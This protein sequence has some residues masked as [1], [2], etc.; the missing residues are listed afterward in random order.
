MSSFASGIFNKKYSENLTF[1][2]E[3]YRYFVSV[4]QKWQ[5]F[6]DYA[7][8]LSALGNSL[9]MKGKDIFTANTNGFNVLNHGDL[10]FKNILTKSD[11]EQNDVI[12][13]S[14]PAFKYGL[15]FAESQLISTLVAR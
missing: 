11:E 12:F 15:I 3:S 9:L 13:V 10:N 2:L 5:G 14:I 7:D 1:M 6:E 8:R 4:V